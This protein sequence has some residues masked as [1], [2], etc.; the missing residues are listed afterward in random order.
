MTSRS[1]VE[2]NGEL[3]DLLTQTRDCQ[4]TVSRDKI[5]SVIG[6]ADP[7][8]YRLLPDY[9]TP[10]TEVF[11]STTRCIIEASK[12][13]DIL[14]CCQSSEPGGLPSW[15]P[16]YAKPWERTPFK[17][18]NFHNPNELEAGLVF[19]GR[20]LRVQG[21]F[22]EQI[23]EI[24]EDYVTVNDNEDQLENLIIQWNQFIKSR[25]KLLK[26]RYRLEYETLN[27]LSANQSAE[28]WLEFFSL[29]SRWFTT[30]KPKH[31]P[32][33]KPLKDPIFRIKVR[34]PQ[35]YDP[36]H[37]KSL[38]VADDFDDEQQPIAFLYNHIRKYGIGR[39]L[40]LTRS[41]IIG[42][43]PATAKVSDTLAILHGS[44]LPF[45]LRED[46]DNRGMHSLVGE[47]CKQRS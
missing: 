24:S 23:S 26:R 4:A 47:A 28:K 9:R 22:I 14:C 37:L 32:E 43:V 20:I 41:C 46:G 27:E 10:L 35:G 36:K 45:V 15:V 38:L 34:P 29:Q 33:E 40:C 31:S 11:I 6:M 7:E 25:G 16:K 8:K 17:L 44:S 3:K 1:R 2:N 30:W 39:R 13:I 21:D 42:L 5:F 19:E 18:E 12:R